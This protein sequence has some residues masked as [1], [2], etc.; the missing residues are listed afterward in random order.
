MNIYQERKERYNVFQIE[1]CSR[2]A[3][4][5][6]INS[7]AELYCKI[8]SEH[9][10]KE[11]YNKNDVIIDF[12]YY[13]NSGLFYVVVNS[14]GDVIGFLCISRGYNIPVYIKNLLYTERINPEK[15]YYIS[16]LGVS[17]KYRNIGI[18]TLLMNKFMNTQ[19]PITCFLRT[20]EKE[21]NNV[22]Q[23]YNKY[24][25]K[26]LDLVEKVETLKTNGIKSYDTRIYMFYRSFHID[27][28]IIEG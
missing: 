20:R 15:D 7:A 16:E 2:L 27:D 17:K 13:I 23:F 14:S 3:M 4:E 28:I 5:D 1:N 22:I 6:V 24:N 21:N 12:N 11:D 18:G 26:A 8:F 25:F 10:Y 9:P 19:N